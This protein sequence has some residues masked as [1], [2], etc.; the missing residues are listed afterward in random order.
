M[1]EK[2]EI[3]PIDQESLKLFQRERTHAK[4]LEW[5]N[6]LLPP[7]EFDEKGALIAELDGKGTKWALAPVPPPTPIQPHDPKKLA[8]MESKLD[9]LMK[10]MM[11]INYVP[12]Q[13]STNLNSRYKLHSDLIPPPPPLERS[14]TY[15]QYS[16][17]SGSSDMDESK[18][19]KLEVRIAKLKK[20][21][22]NL[23]KEMVELIREK[24][25]LMNKLTN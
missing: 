22:A 17:F 18:I 25:D 10:S 19:G 13:R 8:E 1:D 7:P 6:V 15:Q 5:S 12:L 14:D 20:Q 23:N 11:G 16:I 21:V 2:Q 3:Q 4:E 24:T 9:G